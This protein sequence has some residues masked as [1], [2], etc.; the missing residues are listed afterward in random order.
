MTSAAAAEPRGHSVHK[1][2]GTS[3]L[4]A[5]EVLDNLLIGGRQG[6]DL[7]N[8]IF[9]VSAYAGMTDLLLENKKTSEPGVFQLYSGS[10][11]GWAW[12]D[13]L[14]QV[15]REM[16]ALN[17]KIF[18]DPNDLKL[19]NVFIHERIEGARS[20]LM[21]LHRLCTFGHFQLEEH[22]ATV[23]EMLS[24]LGE[25]HSAYNT[26]LLLKRHGVNAVFADLSGWREQDSVTLDER[27]E[28]TLEGI[29]L[30]S[31]LP[32]V[33][34]YAQCSEG[35]TG[36]Y[37]RGYSEVTF[38]RIACMTGAREAVI[39]KEFHL[40]SAD[41]K[42]VGE[43][44]VRAIGRT[45]YDV[46]DQL[47]NM[48]ME[49]IH[50]RAAKG[51]R[52]RGI[53]LRITNTFEPDHPG[54]VIADDW[55]SGE[56]QVEMVTGLS[57]AFEIEVFDQDAVGVPGAEEQV[58]AALKRFKVATVA[59]S[60]NA[61]TITQYVAAPLKQV[62]RCV[63]A[64]QKAHPDAQVSTQKVAIVSVIGCNLEAP[65]LV[66]QATGVLAEAGVK[67]LASH[68]PS[69]G[70]DIQLIVPEDGYETA[71]K[72]LHRSFVESAG[73]PEGETLVSA[74]ASAA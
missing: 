22:L 74:E 29:D 18:D 49:A 26:V 4:R 25:A 70:V 47:S 35:L 11:S 41:P 19:A 8:R 31:Q 32:I 15:G 6:D 23:R 20:C 16:A 72:A 30:A 39:H 62:R 1:I 14:S 64:I 2:G 24:A 67:L 51:L 61:N 50:P 60:M 45:S 3:M 46:A 53:P 13:A 36:L 54:T 17:E 12:G 21:D 10:E 33:T 44:A 38:S 37:G 5:Q 73:I 34:G 28:R 65:G 55:Q 43:N 58:V 52:Q 42:I 66:A 56:S 57:N 63:E 59:R 7:Y 48:G 68:S 69:R 40:S 27:I 9:V 71:I